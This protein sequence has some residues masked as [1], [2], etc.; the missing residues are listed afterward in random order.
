MDDKWTAIILI[1]G[2]ICLTLVILA[3]ILVPLLLI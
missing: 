1:V 3:E 2:I